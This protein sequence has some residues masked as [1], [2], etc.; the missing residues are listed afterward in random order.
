MIFYST[1]G[2]AAPSPTAGTEMQHA[3]TG[4]TY[5]SPV[6]NDPPLDISIEGLDGGKA[7]IISPDQNTLEE[8]NWSSSKVKR[9]FISLEQKVLARKASLEES[10]RYRTM[11]RDRAAEIFADRYMR[12]YAEVQRLKKLAE[13]LNEVQKYMRPL[14]F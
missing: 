7:E 10:R 5:E 12:D 11:K 14:T 8:F 13:K 6:M 4:R 9:E 2:S 3:T 1:S